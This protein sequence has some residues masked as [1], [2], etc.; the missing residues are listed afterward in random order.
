MGG[1]G[2][3]EGEGVLAKGFEFEMPLVRSEDDG[4]GKG[5]LFLSEF[6]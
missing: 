3:G 1:F 6:L 2:R 4:V 5:T